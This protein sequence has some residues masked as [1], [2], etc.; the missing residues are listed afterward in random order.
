[1]DGLDFVRQHAPI[2]SRRVSASRD[3]EEEE[4]EE[5]KQVV[6]NDCAISSGLNRFECQTFLLSRGQVLINPIGRRLS[7]QTYIYLALELAPRIGSSAGR[8]L[9]WLLGQ[10]HS[11]FD[12]VRRGKKFV[13]KSGVSYKCCLWNS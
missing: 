7:S 12:W 1:M 10:S 2:R 9:F 8:L 4:E 5:E 13:G 6:L 3:D 11:R